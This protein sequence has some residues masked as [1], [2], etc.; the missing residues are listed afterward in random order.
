MA[1]EHGSNGDFLK[2]KELILSE[3]DDNKS[4]HTAFRKDITN[5]QIDIAVLKAKAAMWGGLTGLIVSLI[6]QAL[7]AIL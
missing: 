3:L 5:N 4:E 1:E 6:I 7:I 2:W